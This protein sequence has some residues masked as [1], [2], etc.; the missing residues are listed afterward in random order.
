MAVFDGRAFT[1]PDPT[2]V[3]NYFIWR[4][5]DATR[6]SIAMAAQA[7]F[8]PGRLHGV[9]CD[10]MQEPLWSE[11][12]V[13]WNDYPAGFKRGRVVTRQ[14]TTRDVVYTDR[15]SGE[16][17]VAIGVTRSAWVTE[18]PPIFTQ[19]RAWLRRAIPR[20]EDA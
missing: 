8:P 4:Q 12:G 18:A 1:I 13:N 2:E 7:H 15:R 19:D 14:T 17:R 16:E 3:E 9:S 6:N 10:R 11:K 5:Q 20:Y